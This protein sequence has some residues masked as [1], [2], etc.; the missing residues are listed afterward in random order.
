MKWLKRIS[1]VLALL[2]AVA[3]AVP[4]FVTLDD[5]I[6]RIEKEASEKLR[7]PVTIK[8][9]KIGTLPLPHV[10]VD[11]ITVGKTEDIK[12]GKVTVTP[13]LFSLLSTH[14][15][16]QVHRA[17]VPGVDAEGDRQDSGVE[18]DGRRQD[19]SATAARQDRKHSLR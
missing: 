5:Y 6:P 10:T 11:G 14:Q 17:E 3:A 1:I 19:A 15:S 13:D 7:E 2:L 12:L 16:H 8:S 9:I 4:F 18:Q